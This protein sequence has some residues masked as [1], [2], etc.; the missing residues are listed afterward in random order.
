[1]LKI[2]Q[3]YPHTKYHNVLLIYFL[4][5]NFSLSFSDEIQFRVLFKAY[6]MIIYC[7]THVLISNIKLT[8]RFG[9]D[10]LKHEK[11][12]KCKREDFIVDM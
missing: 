6:K 7:Y 4:S 5:L 9:P 3:H 12:K 8:F 10:C 1:M 11:E 2:N